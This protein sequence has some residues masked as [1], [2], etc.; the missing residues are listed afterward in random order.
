MAFTED[1]Y[2]V[3]GQQHQPAC[4]LRHTQFWVTASFFV[5]FFSPASQSPGGVFGQALYDL[6]LL[7]PRERV[8]LGLGIDEDL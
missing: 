3:I 7:T 1:L 2:S 6:S 4:W 5:F 8:R